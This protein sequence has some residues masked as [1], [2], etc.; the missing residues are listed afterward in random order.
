MI[1]R[2][3]LSILLL[4]LPAVWSVYLDLRLRACRRPDLARALGPLEGLRPDKYTTDA[5]PLL[6]RYWLSLILLLVGAF[7]VVGVLHP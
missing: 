4:A 1:L 3:A 2:W 6:T 5:Y 7:V